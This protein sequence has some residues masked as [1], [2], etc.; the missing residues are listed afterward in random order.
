MCLALVVGIAG[1]AHELLDLEPHGFLVDSECLTCQ[2]Y[3]SDFMDISE[4]R[5]FPPVRLTDEF[6]HL[7]QMRAN[8]D[9]RF[10]RNRSP[11]GYL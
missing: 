10:P 11:P 9:L 8:A 4:S 5:L 2:V 1:S 6:L 7:H 3:S